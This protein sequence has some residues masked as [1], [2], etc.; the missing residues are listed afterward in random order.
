M[1][2]RDIKQ[3]I[4]NLLHRI[5][6]F[7]WKLFLKLHSSNETSGSKQKSIKK[8]PATKHELSLNKKQHVQQ[9]WLGEEKI[10]NFKYIHVHL[11]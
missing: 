11:Q 6:K 9:L 4:N 10:P 8:I 5:Q 2:W 7:Q 1:N 3:C